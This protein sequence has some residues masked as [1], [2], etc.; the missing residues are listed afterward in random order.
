MPCAGSIELG[1]AEV[2]M[3]GHVATG[4]GRLRSDEPDD[5]DPA[6]QPHCSIADQMRTLDE[7]LAG[8]G[9]GRSGTREP[10]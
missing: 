2:G 5:L 8:R 7:N 9:G 10:E 1:S 6:R 4:Q 3:R